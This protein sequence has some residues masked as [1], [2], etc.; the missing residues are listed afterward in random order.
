MGSYREVTPM[1]RSVARAT[2]IGRLLPRPVLAAALLAAC[3]GD[4]DPSS[5]PGLPASS[6]EAIEFVTAHN[7]V[8]AAVTE[9]ADYP[10]VWEPLPPVIW[11]ETVSASARTW[12]NHLREANGCDLE[13]EM[14]GVYGEN[15]AGGGGLTPSGAVDLWAS[16]KDQ[17]V[18]D[19]TYD[20][21][22]GHYTQIVWRD[23]I[24]I[25][26]GIATCAGARSVA[27]CRYHPP[28]NVIGQQPY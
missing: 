25:G 11:S 7:A 13:H 5:V 20:F 15:L 1:A 27:S 10:G 9:P 17:Y 14:S 23:S 28:G 26:C 18:F 6:P 12:A 22:A 3:G 8:R 19:P 2:P 21:V 24:E 4:D 16:E